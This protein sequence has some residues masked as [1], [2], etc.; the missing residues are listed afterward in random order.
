MR[1]GRMLVHAMIQPYAPEKYRDE[2][3][4]KLVSAI[5]RKIEGREIIAAAEPQG[6]VINLMEA[7]ERSL[8]QQQPQLAGV[9]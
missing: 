9:H 6:N 1:M 4:E 7:L 3:E 5:Q 2:Y 8:A